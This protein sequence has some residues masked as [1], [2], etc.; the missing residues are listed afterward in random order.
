MDLKLQGI[1]EA[2]QETLFVDLKNG[3]KLTKNQ[4]KRFKS[5]FAIDMEDPGL[6]ATPT[7]LIITDPPTYE[8]MSPFLKEN[9]II[10]R[11]DSK[12]HNIF[13]VVVAYYNNNLIKDAL[14]DQSPE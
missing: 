6:F 5:F 2:L 8:E 3:K 12:E 13:F 1:Y 4:L 9:E 14:L 11:V 7:N 10:T